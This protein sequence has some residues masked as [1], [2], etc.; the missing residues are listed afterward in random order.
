MRNKIPSSYYRGLH[1]RFKPPTFL[2]K[3]A[4]FVPK[5]AQSMNDHFYFIN[6]NN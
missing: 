4:V 1:T 3:F 5:T 2:Y 6:L